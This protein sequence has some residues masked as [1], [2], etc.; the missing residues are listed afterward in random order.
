MTELSFENSSKIN[1]DDASSM[2]EDTLLSEE[3]D[4]LSGGTF[5][6]NYAIL[7][8]LQSLNK[9]M[10]EIGGIAQ[11][12]K[13]DMGKLRHP[14]RQNLPK[15]ENLRQRAMTLTQRNPI[16]IN[17]WLQTNGIKLSPTGATASCAK[18]VQMKK[19]ILC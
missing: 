13:T 9:N 1:T 7:C 14:Q 15:K 2:Q 19:A 17:C 8:V 6:T 16:Q 4:V 3:S 11:V 12:F 18:P 10:T 5:N